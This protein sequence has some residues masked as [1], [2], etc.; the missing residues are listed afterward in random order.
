[1]A[2]ARVGLTPGYK[3]QPSDEQLVQHFL[4]PY[5]REQPVPLLGAAVVRDDPRSAPPWEL[6]ARNGRGDEDD[7]YF[8]APADGGG[9]QSRA[10]AGGRGKWITQ[11]LER[12]AEL[13]L[14]GSGSVVFEKHRLNFHAGEG[15]CGSTGWVMH[16]FAV[17]KPAM[18]GARH[19]A[20]HIAFTGH[21]QKRQ[22]VPNSV[23][24]G[25]A[26]TAASPPSSTCT[27][28]TQHVPVNDQQI[29]TQDYASQYKEE[30]YNEP[31]PKRMKL[32]RD[33]CKQQHYLPPPA[34]VQINQDQQCHDCDQ[35]GCFLPEQGNQEQKYCYNEGH[36][37]P[38][39][40]DQEQAN[41]DAQHHLALAAGA[42]PQHGEH[43]TTSQL[44]ND[45]GDGTAAVPQSGGDE[46]MALELTLT[47]E[48]WVSLFGED[49]FPVR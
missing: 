19:R 15:R 20:C 25:E 46:D 42:L 2:A 6:F 23:G 7:A 30:R 8:L 27:A 5:L 41:Y 35:Q 37:L 34:P 16:E 33:C 12:T 32:E 31:E 4:L 40:I 9:R 21:G 24:G 13:V 18:L 47:Q 39:L 14:A 26:S 11:R 28:I 43:M 29:S 45:H 44:R 1:M 49:F 22:R 48:D 10:L 17:V 38:Q 3:F 36:F